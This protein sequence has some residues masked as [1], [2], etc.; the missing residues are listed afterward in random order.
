MIRSQPPDQLRRQAGSEQSLR[1]LASVSSP[2]GGSRAERRRATQSSTDGTVQRTI[3]K[4][5]Q[6]VPV[7][8]GGPGLVTTMYLEATEYAPFL[9]LR[10]RVW[11]AA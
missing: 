1:D 11:A 5:T 6:K 8:D 3:H 10:D 7:P 4:L 2:L 9:P